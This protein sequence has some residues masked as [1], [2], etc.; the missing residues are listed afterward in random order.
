[1]REKRIR[2]LI[3]PLGTGAVVGITMLGGVPAQAAPVT[4][5]FKTACL[6]TPS[7]VAGPT[8][9]AQ[10][11]SV[12]I[13][14]PESVAA[15]EEFEVTIIPPP[16]TFPNSASGAT[17]QNVSR[18][19]IDVAI[20]Q[21][22][23]YLG[24]D[25]VAGTSVGLSGVTPNVLRVNENGA[26]DANGSVLRLSGNNVVIGNSPTS[27]KSSEGGIVAKAGPGSETTFQLPQVRA[28]LKAGASGNVE[29]K[30]RTAGD[31]GAWANDKNF[32]TFLPKASLIVTAWAPTQCT[33]RDSESAP[34]NAGAGPLSTTRIV[35]ADKATT[36]T[37]S[38]PNAAKNGS[39][40]TLT[41]NVAPAANGGTVQFKDGDAPLGAPVPVT[42][43][44]AIIA[45]VFDTDGPHSITA[46]YSG[47]TG[48]TGSVSAAKVITVTTDAPPDAVTTTTVT[49]P[50]NAKVGQDVNLTA[51][52]T[53]AGTGGT[54]EFTVDG[55]AP[56]P[57]MVGSDGVAVAP[58][59][60]TSTG[61]HKVVARFTGVSGYAK[62]VS[63]AFP[64]SVTQPAAAD[65]ET[66]T[67]LD[68]VGTVTRNTPVT[69]RATVAP[70][71]A[72]GTV[73]FKLGD[74]PLGA[75]VEVVDGVATLPTTFVSPGTFNVTAE[76]VG[77]PGFTASA[78]A[79]QTLTVP[80]DPGP[81][82]GGGTGS[83]DGLFGGFGS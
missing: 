60:F 27:S 33:P 30:L 76:F 21:N 78:S 55:G 13:D 52:V 18:I 51:K 75:P 10:D 28:R 16:I 66:T 43:G 70:G 31:A 7:A 12:T 58:Y 3:T 2:R 36:T 71:T 34:L 26:V 23:T 24:A 63:P 40:V 5:P 35:E 81:G 62:S 42:G 17:V 67:T 15:G 80:G 69:L 9:Q 74:A 22:A 56:V 45:P 11:A 6:A 64:V 4:T 29:I 37:I 44:A 82:T 47:T 46:E 83:L 79:P 20:P 25:T 65:V 68:A 54:V 14:A 59:T 38:G 49:A 72:K 19:K 73:Q 53:P 48:F 57:G 32:L 50:S 1:M 61:T 8:V 39:P 77:A 41:A